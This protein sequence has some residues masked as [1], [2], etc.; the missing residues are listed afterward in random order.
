MDLTTQAVRAFLESMGP[1]RD[2]LD[3]LFRRLYERPAVKAVQRY[4]LQAKPSPDFGLSA[5][6]HNGAIVDF[7]LELT[8]EGT[9]WELEYY[10]ARHDPDEDGSHREVEFPSRTITSVLEMPFV[11]TAAIQELEKAIAI[12]SLF[13]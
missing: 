3:G 9:S 11:L 1:V 5:E 6:L 8:S 13:R 2:A 10:V 12:P 4:H 7:W